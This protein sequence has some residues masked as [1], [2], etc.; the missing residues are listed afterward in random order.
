MKEISH[1]SQLFTGAFLSR[2]EAY[3]LAQE[4]LAARLGAEQIAAVLTL[5]AQRGNSVEE[6]RGFRC[7]LLEAAQSVNLSEYQ[8]IDVCGTGGDGKNSFNISTLAAFVV[9]GAGF[10]VAK[11]G[12]YA[13][14]SSCGSSNLLEALGIPFHSS[15]ADL[16]K[17]LDRAG[18]CFLHAPLFHPALKHLAP[19]R[20]GLGFRTIFNLLGPL[21]N[22]AKP[23]FRFVGV[24]S[25]GIQRLVATLLAEEQE[26]FKVVHSFAGHDEIALAGAWKENSLEM[27]RVYTS[28]IFGIA[29]VDSQELRACIDLATLVKDAVDILQGKGSSARMQVVC[30]NAASAIHL[31]N[32]GSLRDCF[33]TAQAS[34]QSGRAYM[35]LQKVREQA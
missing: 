19:I 20:K 28:E 1:L 3:A 15:E 9:A 25:P 22:P 13:A 16:R 17:D 30:A 10:K 12:N 4:I 29:D 24:A 18:I 21:V 31:I 33:E 5:F 7:A 6:L 23:K 32:G 14:S 8:A 11:H 26:A 27:E 2:D 35:V 34:L